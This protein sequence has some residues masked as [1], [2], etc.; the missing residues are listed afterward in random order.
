M[1]NDISDNP[2]GSVTRFAVISA[3][4]DALNNQT[5]EEQSGEFEG[6]ATL[7]LVPSALRSVP[8]E[9]HPKSRSPI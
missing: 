1:P 5:V 7:F 6:Q 9:A 8:L 3:V 2:D 4:V